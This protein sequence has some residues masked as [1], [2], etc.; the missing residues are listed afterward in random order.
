MTMVQE[1]LSSLAHISIEKELIIDLEK[2]RTLHDKILEEF[3]LKPRRLDFM[4]K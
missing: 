2:K 1:Q 4:F 3:A